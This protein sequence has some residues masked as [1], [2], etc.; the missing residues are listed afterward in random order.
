LPRL[1]GPCRRRPRAARL[2]DLRRTAGVLV[3]RAARG[4]REP[5]AAAVERAMRTRDIVAGVARSLVD[6]VRRWLRNAPPPQ[7]PRPPPGLARCWWCGELTA[8]PGRVHPGCD[9]PR[10]QTERSK[11]R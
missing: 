8:H 6:D 3:R 2:R 7:P 10:T 9:L 11:T 5:P 1:R 4:H